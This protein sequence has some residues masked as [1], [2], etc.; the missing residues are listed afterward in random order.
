MGSGFSIRTLFIQ[1]NGNINGEGR[2]SGF[3]V[4]TSVV[5]VIAMLRNFMLDPE[6]A[7]SC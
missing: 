7:S 1:N 5:S 6:N 2:F 3:T 4:K